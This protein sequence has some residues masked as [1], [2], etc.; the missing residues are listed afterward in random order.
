MDL[1]D[2]LKG[3][4]GGAQPA[5]SQGGQGDLI[6]KL[7]PLVLQMLQGRQGNAVGAAAGG[8]GGLGSLAGLGG[9][10]GLVNAFSQ[11]GLGD[12]VGSWIGRGENLPVSGRQ[13]AQVL[14][15]DGIRH[16]AGRTG[17]SQGEVTE[18][19]SQILPQV[20]DGLTPEG[21][22]PEEGADAGRATSSGSSASLPAESSWTPGAGG[23]SRLRPGRVI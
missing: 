11:N 17:A 23:E 9:L 16:L 22:V 5:A 4:L 12:L 10:G 7:L 19:L 21:K 1:T 2:L 18:A 15:D 8:A 3:A 20:V 14:G 13:L 6:A